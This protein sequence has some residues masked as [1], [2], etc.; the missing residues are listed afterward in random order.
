MC[1]C[2]GVRLSAVVGDRRATASGINMRTGDGV[3]E[4]IAE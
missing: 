4:K 1:V 2:G 3:R